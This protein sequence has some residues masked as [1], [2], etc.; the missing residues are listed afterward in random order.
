MASIHNGVEPQDFSL[1][2]QQSTPKYGVNNYRRGNTNQSS[3]D[4]NFH[5]PKIHRIHH[6]NK[7][8]IHQTLNLLNQRNS[9]AN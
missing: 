1:R 7:S 2:P 9:L 5:Q 4:G 3:W 8:N 6:C